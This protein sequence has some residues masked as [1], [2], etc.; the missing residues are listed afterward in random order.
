MRTNSLKS[1]VLTSALVLFVCGAALAQED[2][3]VPANNTTQTVPGDKGHRMMRHHNMEKGDGQQ[4]AMLP[5]LTDAQKKQMTELRTKHMEAMLPIKNQL[6]E[7]KAHLQTL[8]TAP[9]VDNKEVDKVV[10]EISALQSSSLKE[11][12]NHQQQVRAILTPEQRVIFDSKPKPFF[13][14]GCDGGHRKG[15]MNK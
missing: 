7:K 14:E 6:N 8:L 12:I 1:L 10:N 2:V 9:T 5:N 4:H 15:R 13:I 11:K 3:N